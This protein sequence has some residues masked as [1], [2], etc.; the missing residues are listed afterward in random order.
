MS[1]SHQNHIADVDQVSLGIVAPDGRDGMIQHA[2]EFSEAGIPF[3]FDPGQG[4]PMFNREELLYFVTLADYAA[5]NEYEAKMLEEKTGQTLSE[6]AANLKALI[7][8]RGGAGSMIYANG[9]ILDIPL[10]AAKE[11]V[12]PTGCGDSYRSGLLYGIQEGLDW[13]T[14]GRLASLLGAIK[15]ESRGPQ[16]HQFDR[17]FIEIKYKESFG[18]VLGW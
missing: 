2:K 17:T 12:D 3:V 5:M 13:E 8:T 1:F 16:N 4:L 11:I 6:I 10:V 18:R 7:V 15:I 9:K 14:T